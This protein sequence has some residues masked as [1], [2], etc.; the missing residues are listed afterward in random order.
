[1][2][3]ILIRH[4]PESLSKNSQNNNPLKTHQNAEAEHSKRRSNAQKFI[5]KEVLLICNNKIITPNKKKK[6]R[7]RK[8]RQG[9]RV[10]R[11]ITSL[12]KASVSSVENHTDNRIQKSVQNN[13]V[14][15]FNEINKPLVENSK[16]PKKKNTEDFNDKQDLKNCVLRSQIE[17]KSANNQNTTKTNKRALR[18]HTTSIAL[19][20]LLYT[21]PSNT[22]NFHNKN[23]NDISTTFVTNNETKKEFFEDSKQFDSLKNADVGKTVKTNTSS[24]QI[25]LENNNPVKSLETIEEI[26]KNFEDKTSTD[27]KPEAIRG[28]SMEATATDSVRDPPVSGTFDFIPVVDSNSLKSDE[29]KITE[30][31][32]ESVVKETEVK[33]PSLDINSNPNENDYNLSN[34][35]VIRSIINNTINSKT[36]MKE[37]K[38]VC[39]NTNK[40]L[41]R[42]ALLSNKNP[43][44]PHQLTSE[45]LQKSLRQQ[46]LQRH[47]FQNQSESSQSSLK[48]DLNTSHPTTHSVEPTKVQG[49]QPDTSISAWEDN[50]V[51]TSEYV[52][53]SPCA[54][55][56]SNDEKVRGISSILSV[57]AKKSTDVV[58]APVETSNFI[59]SENNSILA[60]FD[61]KSEL[62]K[63]ALAEIKAID[64]ENRVSTKKE[65]PPMKQKFQT[66]SS[67]SSGPAVMTKFDGKMTKIMSVRKPFTRLQQQQQLLQISHH[68]QQFEDDETTKKPA[69]TQDIENYQQHAEIKIDKQEAEVNNFVSS[70]VDSSFPHEESAKNAGKISE[71]PNQQVKN[72]FLNNSVQNPSVA[73]Q[74]IEESQNSP[75]KQIRLPVHV[76]SPTLNRKAISIVQSQSHAPQPTTTPHTSTQPTEPSIPHIHSTQPQQASQRRS[77]SN[78]P[79]VKVTSKSFDET[80]NSESFQ[81]TPINELYK[82]E[83][84]KN[85][86]LPATISISSGST[87]PAMSPVPTVK[88]VAKQAVPIQIKTSTSVHKKVSVTS[89][90]TLSSSQLTTTTITTT[91]A[92]N[93]PVSNPLVFQPGQKITYAK[94]KAYSDKEFAEGPP[95]QKIYKQTQPEPNQLSINLQPHKPQSTSPTVNLKVLQKSSQPPQQ[96]QPQH[97][98]YSDEEQKNVVQTSG[99]QPSLNK[100]QHVPRQ[101]LHHQTSLRVSDKDRQPSRSPLRRAQTTNYGP[102]FRPQQFQQLINDKQQSS[103]QP[104]NRLTIKTA[105]SKAVSPNMFQPVEVS[106]VSSQQ[107]ILVPKV[108][109]ENKGLN[110]ALKEPI[111][112]SQTSAFTPVIQKSTP[113]IVSRPLVLSPPLQIKTSPMVTKITAIPQVATKPLVTINSEDYIKSESKNIEKVVFLQ[114]FYERLTRTNYHIN[115]GVQLQRPFI[116]QR[117]KM[118]FCEKPPGKI[119]E[120]KRKIDIPKPPTIPQQDTLASHSVVKQQQNVP[121][122]E[123]ENDNRIF[124][125]RGSQQNSIGD[126]AE[127]WFEEVTENIYDDFDSSDLT[128]PTLTTTDEDEK[129]DQPV[130]STANT[131]GATVPTKSNLVRTSSAGS[132]GCGS[133]G[134]SGR[135]GYKVDRVMKTLGKKED[136]QLNLQ[137]KRRQLDRRGLKL[138]SG[139]LVTEQLQQRKLSPNPSSTLRPASKSPKPLRTPKPLLSKEDAC[140]IS[141]NLNVKLKF[142]VDPDLV[143]MLKMRKM[144]IAPS[145]DEE[146]AAR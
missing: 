56:L 52:D 143:K 109:P 85:A 81:S 95:K 94:L 6:R 145:S 37:G 101:Q 53:G 68:K 134:S 71:K 33:L 8:A 76:D 20:A 128:T 88:A 7:V 36:Q 92:S 61:M 140:K 12:A 13:K 39:L 144:K 79:I 74:R 124:G 87:E 51:F 138:Q 130:L 62:H 135:V 46:R 16:F 119:I 28:D 102:N 15:N 125:K 110:T 104:F 32:E 141:D 66:G 96:T 44:L 10:E 65:T 60:N 9:K 49:N 50:E 26:N 97:V 42:K 114:S 22:N 139:S 25:Q 19:E 105:S 21:N 146:S 69:K 83:I 64:S 133:N 107:Q 67:D 77:R 129:V 91:S 54:K 2:S 106:A 123:T 41:S 131:S 75:L 57:E 47:K 120:N 86:S 82:P 70:Y 3:F 43:L 48:S 118:L 103:I 24:I 30:N 58:K 59:K 98:Y 117:V 72:E 93:Q 73:P 132:G 121:T 84:T 89:T 45:E 40:K 136:I 23:I 126:G 11:S 137:E 38:I 111:R 122:I 29:K 1:M 55:V 108:E 5:S 99:D 113:Q 90:S 17:K 18:R 78:T 4:P 80:K 100:I 115:V 112:L 14:I 116:A 27:I 34:N 127:E 35:N 142:G 31:T 63:K